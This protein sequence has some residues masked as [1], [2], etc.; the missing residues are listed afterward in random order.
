MNK[1]KVLE[2]SETFTKI[3]CHFAAGCKQVALLGKSGKVL[4]FVILPD[5]DYLPG[6]I[7]AARIAGKVGKS[8]YFARIG[9]NA[10]GFLPM[11]SGSPVFTD[12]EKV[13]VKV[14]KSAYGIKEAKLTSDISSADAQELESIFEKTE[15][16]SVI[17]PAPD[18]LLSFLQRHGNDLAKIVCDDLSDRRN[19]ENYLAANT[20]IHTR[21]EYVNGNSFAEYGLDEELEQAAL[22][23]VTTR[24]GIRLF[25]EKTQAFWSVDVD[26]F[27][28]IRSAAEINMLAAAEILRQIRLRN[29][30]G[31]IV[32]DFIT[33]QRH[34]I[35]QKVINLIKEELKNGSAEAFLAGISPLGHAEIVRKRVYPAVSEVVK[36]S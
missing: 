2:Y 7:C 18:I 13:M 21:I 6:A 24:E 28:C 35:S 22:P 14:V 16:P 33:D 9:L 31:Q 1:D 4:E 11:P 8:A 17:R 25:I 26:S 27:Q 32:I 36:D 20:D 12:G 34:R 23:C 5:D 10:L 3:I 30:S 29:M 19:V 15:N